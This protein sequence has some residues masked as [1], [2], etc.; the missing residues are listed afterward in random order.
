MVESE[1]VGMYSWSL[2]CKFSLMFNFPTL[3]IAG[4]GTERHQTLLQDLINKRVS[5]TRLM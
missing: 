1:V 4:M 3:A 5:A 2:Q